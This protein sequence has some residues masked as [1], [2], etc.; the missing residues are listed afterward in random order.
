M[1]SIAIVDDDSNDIRALKEMLERYFKESGE[2]YCL[3][4]FHD[5]SELMLD[6]SPKYDIV[7]L[8]IDMKE[9]N[10]MAAAKRIRMTDEGTAIIFV[11]HMA[12]YAIK[13]YEVSAL[14]FIV[15]PLDYYSFAL[16]IK[17]ALGYVDANRKKLVV[18]K[19]GAGTRYI[20]ENDIKYVETLSHYLVYHTVKGDFTLLGTLKSAAEQLSAESFIL[21][22]RCYLVNM[23][24]VAE[25]SENAVRVGDDMLIISRYR[26]K[27]FMDALA[28]FWG[29]R[30]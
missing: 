15:K 12:K 10:G 7:F 5:G 18:L 20:D 2:D 23:R 4:E 19:T 8:D 28:K 21:C 27:E 6:Y 24:Y 26:R 17:R 16:K 9:L 30:G 13:G 3:A 22:N 14:D 25:I 1:Y 29:S 11:T